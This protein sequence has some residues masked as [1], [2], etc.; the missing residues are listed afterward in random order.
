MGRRAGCR[1]LHGTGSPRCSKDPQS[2]QKLSAGACEALPARTCQGAA[3]GEPKSSQGR[4]G[5]KGLST[6]GPPPA[7]PIQ[8][9]FSHLQEEAELSEYI[10]W[11]ISKVSVPQP[12]VFC[13]MNPCSVGDG[14]IKLLIPLIHKLLKLY[15]F[16]FGLSCGLSCGLLDL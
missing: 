2:P 15:L 14:S 6:P 11:V 4:G 5:G 10:S 3:A 13:H 1:W 16:L 9:A 8:T 12:P 7:P